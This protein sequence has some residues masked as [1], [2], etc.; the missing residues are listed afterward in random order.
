VTAVPLAA[1]LTEGS[2]FHVFV[3]T[4]NAKD[5]FDRRPVRLGRRDDQYV[6]ITEGLSVGEQVAIGGVQELRTAY[7]SIK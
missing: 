2:E 3:K 5:Y 4:L 1:V 7:A 6:E